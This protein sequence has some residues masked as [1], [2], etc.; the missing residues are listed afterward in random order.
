MRES[1]IT[2]SSDLE[3][4]LGRVWWYK[5]CQ[6][7]HCFFFLSR[8]TVLP[9]ARPQRHPSCARVSR[10]LWQKAVHETKISAHVQAQAHYSIS[11]G[12]FFGLED[13]SHFLFS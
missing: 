7:R 10:F 6:C 1:T 3:P 12:H 9:K 5:V 2:T 11:L 8:A 13:F 4:T